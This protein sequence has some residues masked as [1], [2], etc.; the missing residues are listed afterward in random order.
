VTIEV[1]TPDGTV[2]R[3]QADR[4]ALDDAGTG[5]LYILSSDDLEHA[6]Y[7]PGGWLS[8]VKVPDDAGE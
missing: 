4:A 5:C 1:T 7:A 6:I 3:Y 2:H 8:A